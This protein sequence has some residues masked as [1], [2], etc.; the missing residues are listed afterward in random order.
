MQ[1]FNFKTVCCYFSKHSSLTI[2]CIA[3]SI[4]RKDLNFCPKIGYIG[5]L[6][7]FS[8][9]PPCHKIIKNLQTQAIECTKN[10][11]HFREL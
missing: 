3:S 5:V 7:H 10:A 8:K 2:L 6:Q 1:F 11:C 9:K 4:Q